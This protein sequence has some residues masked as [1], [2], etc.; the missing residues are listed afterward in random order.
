MTRQAAV[1]AVSTGGR[2]CRVI[3]AYAPN[4]DT[5]L[6]IVFEMDRRGERLPAH[7][8]SHAA[9]RQRYTGDQCRLSLG[10]GQHFFD[11]SCVWNAPVPD[12]IAPQ[13]L[14]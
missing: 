5:P 3:L 9:V 8:F 13:A 14:T 11:R 10:R 6:D 1:H 4:I 12:L 2:E 7:W